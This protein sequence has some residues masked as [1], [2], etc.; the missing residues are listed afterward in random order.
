MLKLAARQY[1]QQCVGSQYLT[2]LLYGVYETYE[3]IDFSALPQ[4]FILK[5]NHGCGGHHLVWIRRRFVRIG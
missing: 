2:E 3:D 1:V 5:T 4:R